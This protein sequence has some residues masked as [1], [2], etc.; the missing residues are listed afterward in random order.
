MDELAK[1]TL[2]DR[3]KTPADKE[4]IENAF[5]EHHLFSTLT[6]RI[7]NKVIGMMQL[8]A[9][10]AMQYLFKQGNPGRYVFVLAEGLA[11]IHVNNKV[12][13][14]IKQSET[15]GEKGLQGNH[16]RTASVLTK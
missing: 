16:R 11:E 8:A 5:K 14:T 7:K 10:N 6:D 2:C 15:V 9:F 13:R 3:I 4:I 1:A 12:V